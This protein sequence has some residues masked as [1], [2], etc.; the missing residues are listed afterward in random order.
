M[1]QI[2]AKKN[3]FSKKLFLPNS[4]FL[5]NFH[6]FI[7]M[8]F[9]L[10]ILVGCNTIQIQ[11]PIKMNTWN[12]N[13]NV[14][15][16]FQEPNFDNPQYD[17]QGFYRIF[18][19]QTREERTTIA[20]RSQKRE[21][22]GKLSL[23]RHLLRIERWELDKTTKNYLRAKNLLQLKPS[24][25]YVTIKEGKLTRIHYILENQGTSFRREINYFPDK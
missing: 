24:Q 2:N 1:I 13:Y 19:D 6:W 11:N 9:L 16:T 22:K 18:I 8:F 7:A 25:F 3:S 23:D 21:W 20:L 15:I 12:G 14:E 10:F 4:N 17:T 5:M